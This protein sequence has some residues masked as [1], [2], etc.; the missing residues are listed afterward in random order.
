MHKGRIYHACAVHEK[1]VYVV[2]GEASKLSSLEIWNGISWRYSDKITV[3]GAQLM[4][5]SKEKNLYL[6][7]GQNKEGFFTNQIWKIEPN[8]RFIKAGTMSKA[9]HDYTLFPI[10]TDFLTNCKGI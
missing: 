4:L 9:R 1:F 2:G 5:Y 6:F 3:G 7:G 10:D 8:E